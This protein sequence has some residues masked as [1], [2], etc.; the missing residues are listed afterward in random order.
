MSRGTLDLTQPGWVILGAIA[1]LVTLGV[2]TVYVTDTHYVSGHDGPQNA[3]RQCVRVLV[4]ALLALGVLC[5]F[6]QGLLANYLSRR[7]HAA[8]GGVAASLKGRRVAASR[9]S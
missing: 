3:M 6:G 9:R 7:K 8:A 2:A 4:G 1:V 5:F